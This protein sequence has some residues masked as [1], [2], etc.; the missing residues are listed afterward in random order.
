MM[1]VRSIVV[2]PH[3]ALNSRA[4]DVINI[5]E[6]VRILA[7]DMADTMY[8]A[9]G[10]GLAANQVG[11]LLRLIVVDVLYPYA[12]PQDKKKKPL[13]VIN[14]TICSFEGE[15]CKEEGCLSVPEFELEVKRAA[16]VQ[17]EGVDLDGKP[18]KI[19]ADGLLARVLQ[20]EI[21]HLNGTT[22]LDHASAL[23]RNLYRRRIKKRSRRDQ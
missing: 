12:E 18:L 15:V 6:Q 9:P 4:A 11:E 5:D 17:V 14:P 2:V 3:G 13:F 16:C 7:L 21:D 10:V 23:K 8:K 1:P 22:L 20:H 19:E